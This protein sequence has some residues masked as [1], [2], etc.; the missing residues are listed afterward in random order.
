MLVQKG[1]NG[2]TLLALAA[3]IGVKDTFEAVLTAIGTRL[4]TQ[5]VG[6]RCVVCGAECFTL[7]VPPSSTAWSIVVLIFQSLIHLMVELFCGAMLSTMVIRIVDGL[8]LRPTFGCVHF[9][10]LNNFGTSIFSTR[11]SGKYML[12]TVH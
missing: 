12:F 8:V 9:H 10:L 2:R 1:F 6:C 7:D 4:D 5:T 3:L 11:E